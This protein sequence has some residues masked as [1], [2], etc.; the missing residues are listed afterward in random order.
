MNKSFLHTALLLG[1]A[2]GAAGQTT[3][4]LEVT[5]GQGP[6]AYVVAGAT[7]DY[8]VTGLLGGDASQGL[9]MFAFD[10]AFD[11][12]PSIPWRR[13]PRARSRSSSRRGLQQP[14]GFG[15]TADAGVC[16]R[17][18]RDEH[19]RQSVRADAPS[20]IVVT[21]FADGAP[22]IL[23]T[24]SVT[25]PATAGTLHALALGRLRER[26]RE[27]GACWFLA[28]AARGGPRAGVAHHHRARLRDAVLLHG[29]GEL[30]RLRRDDPGLRS[31]RRAA[32]VR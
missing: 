11:G 13:R 24:G 12:G 10:A 22:E 14:A 2:A 16:S 29:Q 20:G 31:G 21:G 3:L 7:V 28:G 8:Q 4:Q 1:L 23:A 27:S 32:A 25:A 6:V 17:W 19:D 15:G 5:T 30:R 26:S 9:C 18:R